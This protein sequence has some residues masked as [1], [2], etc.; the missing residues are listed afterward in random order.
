MLDPARPRRVAFAERGD[1]AVAAGHRSQAPVT[2]KVA[3][4]AGCGYRGRSSPSLQKRSCGRG[5]DDPTADPAAAA[6]EACSPGMVAGTSKTRDRGGGTGVARRS[7]VDTMRSLPG[8][9]SHGAGLS[10]RRSRRRDRSRVPSRF[11][12]SC[13]AEGRRRVCALFQAPVDDGAHLRA[14]APAGR[15]GRIWP[16]PGRRR[17]E[18]GDGNGRALRRPGGSA[19][20]AGADDGDARV[21]RGRQDRAAWRARPVVAALWMQ[22]AM[23]P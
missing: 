15:R 16:P 17:L 19:R 11:R 8:R 12:P 4:P 22:N 23:P 5:G 20:R 3:R 7:D 9:G 2:V 14:A 13:Q 10:L 18:D 1:Q 21:R 6:I